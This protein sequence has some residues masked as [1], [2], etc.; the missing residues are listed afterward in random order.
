MLLRKEVSDEGIIRVTINGMNLDHEL[1]RF[2][3]GTT[4]EDDEGI[5]T[6]TGDTFYFGAFKKSFCF[7]TKLNLKAPAKDIANVL[8]HRIVCVK[9]WV[10]ACKA[11]AGEAEVR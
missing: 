9:Q 6:P 3:T 8:N 1:S 4:Y 5:F 2:L 7:S 10:A 11:T